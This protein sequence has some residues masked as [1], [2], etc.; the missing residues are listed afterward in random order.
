MKQIILSISFLLFSTN[1]FAGETETACM[2]VHA[3]LNSKTCFQNYGLPKKEFTLCSF[4]REMA[5]DSDGKVTVTSLNN[6]PDDALGYCEMTYKMEGMNGKYRLYAYTE[7]DVDAQKNLSCK[8]L[9]P[10]MITA[11]WIDLKK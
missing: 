6:C 7:I 4:N 10:G 2:I 3:G 9:L 8:D 5:K 1:I 11:K